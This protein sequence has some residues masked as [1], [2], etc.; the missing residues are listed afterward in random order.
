MVFL[1]DMSGSMSPYL[2]ELKRA[3]SEVFVQQFCRVPGRYLNIVAYSSQV[4]SWREERH[5][6]FITARYHGPDATSQ[7]DTCPQPDPLPRAL[8]TLE[9]R[10]QAY[11]CSPKAAASAAFTARPNARCLR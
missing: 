6:S 5:V 10:R 11:A 1:L 2:E 4:V 3:L 8:P 7:P 9:R